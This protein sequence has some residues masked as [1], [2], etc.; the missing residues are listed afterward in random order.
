MSGNGKEPAPQITSMDSPQ[1]MST[2]KLPIL[3]KGD[4]TLWSMRME[5][6]L[7]NTNYA[8]WEVILNGD[9]PITMIT[10]DDGV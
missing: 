4:Y 10:G 2:I 3:K 9:G 8:L 5:Q 1:M 6:Y 7:T